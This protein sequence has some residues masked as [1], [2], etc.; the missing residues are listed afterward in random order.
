MKTYLFSDIDGTFLQG[1]FLSSKRKQFMPE[2]SLVEAAQKFVADGNEIIFATGRRHRSVRKLESNTGLTANYVISMN[3]ALVH[4]PDNT[5]LRR[6]EI[7][8]DDV[9]QLLNMLKEKHLLKKLVMFTSYMDTKNIVDTHRKPQF[10]FRFL[11]K[12][13]AGMVHR[14]IQIEIESGH[15]H[16]IKFVIVG[17]KKL[18]EETRHIIEASHLQLEV[19][20]SSPYSLEVCAKGANKGEA[21]RFVM[22]HKKAQGQIAYVGD[23]EN[24]IAGL[25]Q[26]DF[27]FAIEGGEP[28]IFQYAN[29][30]VKNVGEA[31]AFLEKNK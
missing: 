30:R 1:H 14:D 9:Q 12:K 16:L 20:K 27:G 31:L 23:S 19:F 28:T 22:E 18:I 6:V 3:G 5:E 21:M 26:A 7:H 24:D 11:A 15:H 13:F 4:G 10:F 25:K 2:Q 8:K 17:K 29:H